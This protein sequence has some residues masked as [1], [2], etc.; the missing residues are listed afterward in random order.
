MNAKLIRM[1]LSFVLLSA[2]VAGVAMAQTLGKVR[3]T[4]VDRET[5]EPLVGANVTIEATTLGAACDVN[6]EFIVL[7][8]PPGNYSLRA[9]YVGYRAMRIRNIEVTIGL[10]TEVNFSLESEAIPGPAIE[11]IAVPPLISKNATNTISLVDAEQIQQL[12]VRNV[13]NIFTL[14]PGVIQQGGNYYVRGG[15]AE[16]TAYYVDGV[17]VNNPMNGALQLNVITN[18]IEQIQ[19]QVGGMTAQYGNAMSAVVSTTTKTCGPKYNVSFELITDAIG[20]TDSKNFLGAYSYGMNEYVLTAS[21]PIIPGND[22]I[23]FFLAGQRMFNRSDPTFLDGINFVPIDSTDI[24]NADWVIVDRNASSGS[25]AT[26]PTGTTGNRAYLA[27][28]LNES[29]YSGGQTYGGYELDLWGLQGNVFM[30]FGPINLKLGGTYSTNSNIAPFGRELNIISVTAGDPRGLLQ[31]SRDWTVYGKWTHIIN[32]TMFY[33]I[34][35][36]AYEFFQETK[37]QRLGDNVEEW[38]N[39]NNPENAVLVGPSRNPPQFNLWSFNVDWPGRVPLTYTKIKR[40]NI[41]GRVDFTKQFGRTWE[42]IVGGEFTRY[43]IRSYG[44]RA[45]NLYGQRQTLPNATDW[46]I[47][48]PQLV[49]NQNF[50]YD[51]YGNE[52]EGGTFTD[53]QGTTVNLSHEGPKNP[54]FA[55][56]YIQNKFEF[57]DLVINFGLRY[58]VIDPGAKQYRDLERIQLD[59]LEGVR[60][61]SEGSLVDQEVAT[62]LSPRIGFSFP[63]TDRT[64]FHATYGRFLQQG[65]LFDLYDG[66][67][68]AA[69]FLAGTFARSSPTPNLKPERTT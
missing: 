1:L 13:A 43:T 63:V 46:E 59:D 16:E 60:A 2:V 27:G 42:F 23:R 49:Y 14:A 18:A 48:A 7:S 3:G 6:G 54:L 28:L 34:Q 66:R 44:V 47:Y 32:P 37:D 67:L 30:D 38:G 62:Q 65:R 69:F 9:T 58:D 24:V 17:L 25:I 45:R 68:S 33:T 4:V 21:G 19:T 8:V 22:R 57:S 41:S 61:I 10:T 26:V 29:N 39:P 36:S 53:N 5:G 12:P 35:L 51:I 52:F 31:E 55:G 15:R 64:V 50:G 40:S 56:A 11:I 20:G